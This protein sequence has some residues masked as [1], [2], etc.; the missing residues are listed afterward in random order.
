MDNYALQVQQAKGLFLTYDQEQ[1][2][3]KFRLEANENWLFLS[4]L[5]TPYRIDRRGGGVEECTPNGWR[6]CED[7]DRVMTLYDLLCFCQG[8]VL[9][10]LSGQ[11]CTVG[12]FIVT[13]ITDTETYTGKFARAFSG[14]LEQLKAA[15]Q[16]LGG[17]LQPPMAGADLT[18]CFPVTDFF[19]VLLQYW[20][21]DEEFPP[22][23]LI[24]WDRNTDQFLRFE[25]T[26]Y[27]QG[28]LL[29]RLYNAMPPIA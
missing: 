1:L 28:D 10:R 9:P 17:R 25:T 7:Y 8:D 19:S 4:Y 21:A 11:W 3:R 22:K 24:L 18:C 13:G 5:N 16:K 14:R 6:P 2:I 29:N 26:F 23:L 15:C 12:T 27:L 20:E